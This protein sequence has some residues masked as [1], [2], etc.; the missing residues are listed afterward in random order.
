M[1]N[2]MH[3]ILNLAVIWTFNLAQGA[4]KIMQTKNLEKVTKEEKVWQVRN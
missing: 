2:R 3:A 1:L 4:R